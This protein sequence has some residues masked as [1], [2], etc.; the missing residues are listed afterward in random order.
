MQAAQ[1]GRLGDIVVAFLQKPLGK[2]G[3]QGRND[4]TPELAFKLFKLPGVGREIGFIG[5]SSLDRIG[6]FIGGERI[7]FSKN[8]GA[9]NHIFEFAHIA[10]EIVCLK[11]RHSYRI[12][13]DN[14]FAIFN[15]ILFYKMLN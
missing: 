15:R 7:P 8:D 5:S 1:P 14:I 9:F 3:L 10:G 6:Q 2:F 12:Y 4:L 11:V 13:A